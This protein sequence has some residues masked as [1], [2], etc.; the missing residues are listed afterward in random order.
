MNGYGSYNGGYSADQHHDDGATNV[1]QMMGT[2]GMGAMAGGMVGGQ[3]LDDIVSQNAKMIRRQS[4]PMAQNYNASP[5][6]LTPDMRRISM[7]DYGANSPA[8]SMNSFQYD[9]SG[10]MDGTGF[11]SGAVTP[12]ASSQ[13]PRRT[14]TSRRLSGGEVSLD[15]SFQNGQQN[16]TSMMAPNSAMDTSPA[17]AS[18]TIDMSAMQA[19]PYIDNS[20]TM[21]IDDY[22]VDAN[23][24][25]SALS[26]DPMHMNLYNQSQF[27]TSNFS[28]PI[29]PSQ[30]QQQQQQ[31]QQ[32]GVTPQSGRLSSHDPGGGSGQHSQYGTLA[33]PQP[34]AGRQLSRTQSLQVPDHLGSPAHGSSPHGASPM[35]AAVSVHSSRPPLQS[36]LSH[37]SN[38]GSNAGF[39]GQPQ[40]PIPGSS[41]D[42]GMNRQLDGVNGPV[43]VKAQN[44]NPNNQNFPWEMPKGG[45]P[46]TMVGKPHMQSVYKNAYSSTGFDMLGVLMRVATR[47]NPELNIGSVDLSCAF[48]VCDAE[49]DDFPIVYCSENFERLTGYT[50]HM[51]LGRNCR[52]LQSPDGNVVPGIRRKYVDDDSVLYLRNM[53]NL[54]REAQ[55]S[56]INYRRGGQPFMNLLTMIPITWDSDQ[57]KFFV[58]FQVDL[59]EQPNAVT[60]KNP[61]GSYSI[62]YQRGMTMPRYVM[63]A[64]D[65]SMKAETGQTVPRDDVSAILSTIGSGESE[66]AKRMWDKVLLENTDDVVHVLSLK[67]LFQWISPSALRVLEY[68]PS[69]IIGTALSSVCHPSDIVPV[70]RELKDTSTG[71]SVNVVFRIRRKL[72]GYM[73]FEGHGSLHTEQGKGRKSI[74]MVGRERPV[75]ALS[76]NEIGIS[77]GIGEHELWTKMSTSGMFLFVSSNVRQLL[78]RQP[79]EL[80]GVSIQSLM[81]TESKTEFGRILEHARTGKKAS[82]KHEMIN[83]RGQVLSAY[84][85]LYPGDAVEGQKPT[86][87]VAQTRLIKFSRGNTS[88]RPPITT[89]K[90][91]SESSHSMG[92]LQTSAALRDGNDTPNSHGS[93][94]M[95]RTTNESATTY[96]GANGLLIGHQDQTLASDDN[97][98][99]E[100]K[101]TKSSS[102]Q[103]E[104]RQL[105]KRNRMLA[106]EVQSLIAA[107]K[108][109][110]RRKG[111]GNQQKDCANCHTRVTPEWRRGP[112]GQRDLCNSCGLRWAKLNG[113][114][115]PRTPSQHS[116][117]SAQSDKASKASASPRH[118]LTKTE[119]SPSDGAHAAHADG[120]SRESPNKT[121][122][123]PQQGPEGFAATMEGAVGVPGKI[124]EGIEPD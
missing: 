43:P 120:T 42:R 101:T 81:R 31:Q 90:D 91:S 72:S 107:K 69:E 5:H 85:T 63:N 30:Q 41:E 71:A 47:P 26:Q 59:V 39:A 61:D 97:L 51:I 60:N 95:Y 99:D 18:A 37:T 75:Y 105:E 56:L 92:L 68:E 98:F 13:Q 29:H 58:G 19:S 57:V 115:S 122:H 23:G 76:K 52:F 108:K 20:M 44:Y 66:Y 50:K 48:V 35:S 121:T 38:T 109:R 82:V 117:Q 64:P 104:I 22:G 12:A 7:M 10:G 45:W 84:T 33:A 1:M 40:H 94:N 79:D 32:G 111:A 89:K 16:Y 88:G 123:R 86:F 87:I 93:A 28:S 11:A 6:H 3:T 102:W 124:D 9:P 15:T 25:S 80:V 96:S 53:V 110:K 119:P 116:V 46:S 114:V 4:M 27:N 14:Q 21:N 62:N 103:Y 113:R 77:G 36:S 83:R 55:I 70:T 73:W 100:L 2:D 17:H 8:A 118:N 106:E 49:K 74:I 65:P 78:D 54:R 34:A 67:G 24:L 112:S